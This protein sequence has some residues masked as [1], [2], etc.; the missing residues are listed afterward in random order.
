MDRE[1][2]L[3]LPISYNEQIHV[4]FERIRN[5]SD[6]ALCEVMMNL[7]TYDQTHVLPLTEGKQRRSFQNHW[8]RNFQWLVFAVRC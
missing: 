2:Y 6:A 4:A 8:L 5:L 3:Q 7:T 1:I